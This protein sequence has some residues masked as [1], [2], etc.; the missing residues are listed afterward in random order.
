M[1]R[2][3]L[4]VYR[5]KMGFSKRQCLQ[6]YEPIVG[7]SRGGGAFKDTWVIVG[8]SRAFFFWPLVREDIWRYTD[9]W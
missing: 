2:A 9:L 4:A 1:E 5:S 3:H 7:C 6:V 8:A